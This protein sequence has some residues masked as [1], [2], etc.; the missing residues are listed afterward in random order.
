[1]GIDIGAFIVESQSKPLKINA[2][3]VEGV[4]NTSHEFLESITAPLLTASTLG[5]VI[6]GSRNIGNQ[7][8][9]LGIF[10]DVS[11]TFDADPSSA[12]DFVDVVYKVE[13][14]PRLYAK[15]GADFGNSDS[16]M[17]SFCLM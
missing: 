16:S 7:M 1:M 15:T 5:E 12:K 8:Q 13:E 9:R 11:I 10:K 3:K 17:V 14:V 2:I 4:V 6:V